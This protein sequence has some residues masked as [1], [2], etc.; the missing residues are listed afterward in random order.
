MTNIVNFDIETK[1]ELDLAEVG[2]Y[3]YA[4][5]PSTDVI[6]L[7][8]SNVIW[9]PR[10]GPVHFH[11]DTI[12]CGYNVLQFDYLIW[13]YILHPQYGWQ[14]PDAFVFEDT[15]H[16]AAYTNLPGALDDVAIALNTP[17]KDPE[18]HKLMLQMCK[19]ARAIKSNSDRWRHHTPENIQRLA[20]YC[21]QDVIAEAAVSAKLPPLPE[22]EKKIVAVDTK[23]NAR[24]MHID[25]ELVQACI[26]CADG[27]AD[28]YR[29]ELDQITNGQVPK[30]TALGEMSEFCRNQGM[31][32]P[33]GA[34]AMDK[35]AIVGYLKADIPEKARRVLK[36]RQMIGRSSLSKLERMKVAVCSD[37][38][39]RGTLQYYGAHQTGRWAG[40]IIQPQNFPRRDLD[41]YDA[42]I[43]TVKM[44][45]DAMELFYGDDSL[46]VITA[47]IRPCIN[48]CAGKQL[49][50]ADYNA[51]ECRVLAWLADESRLLNN[52]RTGRCPYRDMAS[53]IYGV[54]YEAVTDKQ[55]HLGKTIILA[56]GYGMGGK[57][58]PNGEPA[59]FQVTAEL[60]RLIITDA[61]SEQYVDTYRDTFASIPRL[62]YAMD[63]AVKNAIRHPNAIYSVSGIHIKFDG[64]DLK[65]R[66]P[67]GALLWYRQARIEQRYDEE[68]ERMRDTLTFMG[69]IAQGRWGRIYTYG[70]KI[71]ENLCQSI[72][73]DLTAEALVRCENEGCDPILTVHDEIICESAHLTARSLEE[74]MCRSESWASGI[75]VKAKGFTSPYYRK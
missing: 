23:V 62:W 31:V 46:G 67:N 10:S 35:E 68:Y 7:A 61:Q 47:L 36:I 74:I 63:D 9:T 40:R 70:A 8:H 6:C 53:I 69:E 45:P 21:L 64:V 2:G 18:G 48:A 1:S 34:G 54:P 12:F 27:I 11:P 42:A 50:T 75:P 60:Q 43:A 58:R 65:I 33:D 15:M 30:E 13:K 22:S 52:F 57:R 49:V 20:A 51:I 14:H 71:V 3:R 73:R 17:R 72:S 39:I 5:D 32:I 41:D 25:M 38:R 4:M 28:H 37:N 19:P 29:E 59:R 44:G 55:R 66:K 56:C 16:R 24:G 26:D